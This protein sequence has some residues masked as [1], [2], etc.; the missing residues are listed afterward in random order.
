MV[1]CSKDKSSGVNVETG[2]MTATINN[3]KY[4]LNISNISK[5]VSHDTTSLTIEG[6][7]SDSSKSIGFYFKEIK[8][9]GTKTYYC[10]LLS[11][12][13]GGYIQAA[14]FN[15]VT[16]SSYV[17]DGIASKGSVSILT[18]S[19][20]IIQGNF[21]FSAV[22]PNDTTKIKKVS[23]EFN[24]SISAF[25]NGTDLPI[26]LGKMWAQANGASEYFSVIAG[27]TIHGNEK[28]LN[29]TGSLNQQLIIIDFQNFTPKINVTY[30]VGKFDTSDVA[31]VYMTFA[32]SDYISFVADGTNSSTGTVRIAKLTSNN[33]QGEFEFL[34]VNPNSTTSTSTVTGGIFNATLKN[35]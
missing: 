3:V 11:D 10:G 30:K 6:L 12:S 17:C 29:I 32:E 14:Y 16:D 27:N 28:D 22:D 15:I 33:I 2:K 18:Y 34:G 20:D 19:S 9:F 26:A 23:G 8:G 31:K 5:I 24:C 4:T 25:T 35:Y 7:T 1:S 13:S 21:S